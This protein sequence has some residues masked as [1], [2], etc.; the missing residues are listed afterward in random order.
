LPER[1]SGIRNAQGGQGELTVF[2]C[3]LN[4]SQKQTERSGTLSG[5]EAYR[6][7]LH[8]F[9]HAYFQFLNNSAAG[10]SEAGFAGGR[11]V[12]I[13]LCIAQIISGT[14]AGGITAKNQQ[15]DSLLCAFSPIERTPLDIHGSCHRPR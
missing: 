5:T 11:Y 1:Q 10:W 4:L 7:L 13:Q 3:R 2:P 14:T 12:I 9:H 6:H 15:P 8:G